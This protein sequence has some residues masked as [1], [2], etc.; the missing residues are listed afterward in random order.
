MSKKKA[1]TVLI[2]GDDPRIKAIAAKQ[3]S[4]S[5]CRSILA[6]NVT[7]ALQVASK[8]SQIDILLT[9]IMPPDRNG[10]DLAN[11]FIKLYPKARILYMIP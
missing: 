11:Q 10:E 7:E 9:D 6:S 8:Q 5:G 1:A 4:L 2:V 3:E